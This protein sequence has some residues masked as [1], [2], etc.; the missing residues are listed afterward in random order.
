MVIEIFCG[1]S[2]VTAS[3]KQYGLASS[4]GV[5]HI[6]SR[7]AAAQVV[8]ADLCDPQGIALLHQWLAH[9]YVVGIFLA[10]PCGSASRARQIP[11]RGRRG[12]QYGPRP[13]RDDDHP[14]GL[15]NLTMQEKQRVSRANKLYHLTAV[16]ADWAIA[17]G[18]LFCVENPQYS[19]FWATTFW[20]SVAGKFAYTIFHSC[21]YGSSRKKRTMLAHNHPAFQAIRA[22]CPGQNSKHKHAAW[23]VNSTTKKFA[24]SEE[25]A[26]PMGLAKMIAN[27]FVVAL[28]SRGV[29]MPEQ[30]MLEVDD[31]SLSYL[32]KLRATAG[33]QPRASRIPP[34]V[35]TFKRKLQLPVDER[36]S[37]FKL[38]QKVPKT[39]SDELPKGSKLL[40]I[41]PLQSTA[42]GGDDGAVEMDDAG[43]KDQ[44]DLVQTWGIPWSPQEFL[45]QAT[46]VKHPMQ[47]EQLLPKRLRDL[48]VV[49]KQLSVQERIIKR[50]SKLGF[51][52]N[53]A[54]E[55]SV[56]ETEFHASLHPHVAS[57]LKGK[58]L[59]LLKEMIKTINYEDD[60]VFDEFTQ[61]S[62]LVGDSHIS[63]LWPLKFTPATMTLAELSSNAQRERSMLEQHKPMV[64]QDDELLQ[65]VWSQTMDEI[66]TGAL[67]G[68]LDLREIE[69]N[70]PLSR[71]FGI[72]QG[73]KIR[74]VDD[75]SRSGV[76]ACCSTSESP[77]PHTVD[78]IAALCMS[79][80][81]VSSDAPWF[82]RSFD[83]K[84]AYRQCAV[85]PESERFAHI[86]V[87]CPDAKRN[88]AFKMR[89]L[90]FGSVKSVHAFLRMSSCLFS[91]AAAEFAIPVTSYFDDFITICERG[92][93]K[94]VFGCMSGLFKL[95]GWRFAEQGDKAKPF[96]ETVVALGVT[97]NVSQLHT[98]LVT[99]DNTSSRKNEIRNAIDDIIASG[100]LGKL[101]ALRLRGRMQFASGQIFGRLAKKVLA[102]ITG[103]AYGSSTSRLSPNLVTSLVLYKK[104][105]GV[106][107]PREL[108]IGENKSFCVF[109]DASFEPDHPEWQAGL[110]A[111][112]CSTEGKI[113]QYFSVHADAALREKLNVSRRKTIIFE[114]EFFTIWCALH[115][116]SKWFRDSQVVLYTDNDGVRDCLIACQTDSTNGRQILDACLRAEF[117]LRG[118]FWFARVPTDSNIADWPS[119][120][121]L[122][123]FTD[124]RCDRAVFDPQRYFDAMVAY[125][126]M[127]E[128]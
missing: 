103:H 117:E 8:I 41:A 29:V 56:K 74:C 107:V 63:G 15:P 97:L 94:S 120:N 25:T 49:Y 53:R 47:L 23:G 22:K 70:T 64:D 90:P 45:E 121:E 42:I 101:E 40:A 86:V 87:Y 81:T 58:R 33:V 113:I 50:T 31:L 123:F 106:D 61:G 83:L 20:I 82:A 72:R 59:L 111:V 28:Q 5:D 126:D 3:L 27:C 78:V 43:Q 30:S 110:G 57:V 11:L 21:Q 35:P 14:N 2:R 16:L 85:H 32:Q 38:F 6:R 128:A 37:S 100:S 77:K 66:K 71:R 116:W 68:P 13:L 80:A 125:N 88:M 67:V 52:V 26:Y 112:L 65:S 17:E 108:R 89:A 76:N 118:N 39:I 69:V 46:R 91:I 36:T 92:E 98:G 84:Q 19:L 1:T 73:G 9:E 4:F 119:R 24:T 12:S 95:L 48:L 105:L 109:T 93:M 75:F 122:S 104:L 54:K 62:M 127:G 102:V 96:S 99:I 34:L 51:W 44:Q 18:C 124:S 79:L 115:C 10:P 114:L 60:A 55:L 7:Q